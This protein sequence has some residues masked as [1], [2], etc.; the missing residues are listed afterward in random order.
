M[1]VKIL[2]KGV[3]IT[4]GESL[5]TI[6]VGGQALQA[7]VRVFPER[8]NAVAIQ[9]L[10]PISDAYPTRSNW[11]THPKEWCL[12]NGLTAE[13]CQFISPMSVFTTLGWTQ[14]ERHDSNGKSDSV[15]LEGQNADSSL[16]FK[17]K[18]DG[19]IETSKNTLSD[20]QILINKFRQSTQQA[21]VA[22][23]EAET[24]KLA[25]EKTMKIVKIVGFTF[26]GLILAGLTYWGITHL[27]DKNKHEDKDDK[28]KSKKDD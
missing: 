13:E 19:T 27:M 14:D 20:E 24:Q 21:S 4:D 12:A 5:G 7:R 22:M 6:T 18:E 25:H 11:A 28:K 10:F 8:G 15:R 9:T 16:Q 17:I 3:L 26:G 23:S 1:A 2:V